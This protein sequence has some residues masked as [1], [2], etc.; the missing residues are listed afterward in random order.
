MNGERATAENR[1]YE[2]RSSKKKS[3]VEK[4]FRRIPLERTGDRKFF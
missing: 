1:S 2:N 3:R 4:I